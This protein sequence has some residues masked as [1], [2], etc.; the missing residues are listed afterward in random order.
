MPRFTS[1]FAV[2]LAAGSTIAAPL[3]WSGPHIA[4]TRPFEPAPLASLVQLAPTPAWTMPEQALP[5]NGSARRFGTSDSVA[6]FRILTSGT[7]NYFVKLDSV[8]SG[9]TVL[10]VFVRA[11]QQ[12]DIKVPL[13]TYIVKYAAGRSWYGTQHL[14][15]PQTSYAKADTT[16]DFHRQG[17]QITGYSITLYAV[18]GGNLATKSL[19][20]DEF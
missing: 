17:N 2:L 13:G 11:G 8:S 6:P 19:S 18:P 4:A 7:S 10:T 3:A 16:F 12:V 20:P 14:F 9:R 1:H 5:A 15:G